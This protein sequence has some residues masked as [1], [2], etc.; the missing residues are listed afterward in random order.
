MVIGLER[1]RRAFDTMASAAFTVVFRC[2]AIGERWPGEPRVDRKAEEKQG[3]GTH[4]PPI[5]FI[6]RRTCEG[7][8]RLAIS[9]RNS[10]NVRS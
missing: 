2:W 10:H 3:I 4:V 8:H 7:R 6:A 1:K 5:W 9:L